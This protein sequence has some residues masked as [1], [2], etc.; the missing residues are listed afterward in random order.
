MGNPLDL[1]AV[2]DYCVSKGS[3]VRTSGAGQIKPVD[4]S[5]GP[6]QVLRAQGVVQQ[7]NY[8]SSGNSAPAVTNGTSSQV[9]GSNQR[10]L[11]DSGSGSSKSGGSS[12]GGVDSGSKGYGDASAYGGLTPGG[13]GGTTGGG[14]T[15]GGGT[16][17][18]TPETLI[19]RPAGDT[20]IEHV[21][22]R[23]ELVDGSVTGVMVHLLMNDEILNIR[24]SSGVLLRV[25]PEHMIYEISSGWLPARDLTVSSCL[26]DHDCW[27][28]RIIDIY[29][30]T[31]SGLVYNLETTTHTYY[32]GGVLVHNMKDIPTN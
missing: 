26:V 28:I 24:L 25:T 19:S 7:K 15:S 10:Q 11:R 6:A 21:S 32:A 31:H 14:G 8:N 5:G 17:C 13:S 29:R 22:I 30:S 18:F 2:W 4:P 9:T 20:P 12:S 1:R 23:D 27:P 16:S 3:N